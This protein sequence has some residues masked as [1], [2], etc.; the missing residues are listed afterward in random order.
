MNGYE[1]SVMDSWTTI[2]FEALSKAKYT[3]KDTVKLLQPASGEKQNVVCGITRRT[4]A[5]SQQK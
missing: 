5:S 3:L 1:H 2:S 4:E